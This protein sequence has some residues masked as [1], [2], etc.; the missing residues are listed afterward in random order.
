ML[1]ARPILKRF[2]LAGR[3]ALVTGGGEGIGRALA[4]ALG[5]AGAAVAVADIVGSKAAAVANELLARGITSLPIEADV[6][7]SVY[8][9]VAKVREA[10]GTLTIAVNNAGIG[11]WVESAARGI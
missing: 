6:T 4:F 2:S 1:T 9:M 10:W 5:Q 8:G 11:A 3:T 7:D